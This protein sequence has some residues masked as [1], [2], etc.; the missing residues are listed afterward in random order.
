MRKGRFPPF[1]FE[2]P[3]GEASLMLFFGIFVICSAF[4]NSGS[5]SEKMRKGRFP[6][7]GFVLPEF[8]LGEASLMSLSAFLFFI[9]I[10]EFCKV[11]QKDAQGSISPLWVRTTGV[12]L[13]VP[14]LMS[15]PVFLSI[16]A[17]G[18]I[19][20]DLAGSSFG[21]LSFGGLCLS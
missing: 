5:L 10:F 11:V 15:L 16:A 20:P 8:G 21:G 12:W 3:V 6:P 19:W 2:L 4:S 9:C 7:F 14:F 1:G 13:R 17:F 18:R